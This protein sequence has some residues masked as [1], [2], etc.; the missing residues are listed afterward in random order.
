MEGRTWER[1]LPKRFRRSFFLK[2]FLFTATPCSPIAH[3]IM[4]IVTFLLHDASSVT[5][6]VLKKRRHLTCV[7]NSN[8][9]RSMCEKTERGQEV[10]VSPY[11]VYDYDS[12]WRT[13]KNFI[14]SFQ[15]YMREFN[16]ARKDLFTIFLLSSL[17]RAPHWHHASKA[18]LLC[19]DRTPPTIF[20]YFPPV[21]MIMITDE[22][23]FTVSGYHSNMKVYLFYVWRARTIP[24]WLRCT[25]LAI[26]KNEKPRISATARSQMSVRHAIIYEEEANQ[27]D[28]MMF[29][30]I[31]MRNQSCVR[32]RVGSNLELFSFL[33]YTIWYGRFMT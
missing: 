28:R 31:F 17:S 11:R 16:M 20:L 2:W 12:M 15:F 5:N 25:P 8:R 33:H 6:L 14:R 30:W 3:S 18:T 22:L 7:V 26:K 4:T 23:P 13:L 24:L 9:Y 29:R 32:Q 19:L 21:C 27:N 1:I 10:C